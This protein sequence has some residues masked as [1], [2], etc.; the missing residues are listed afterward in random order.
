MRGSLVVGLSDKDMRLLDIFEGDVSTNL[1][2]QGTMSVADGIFCGRNIHENWFS[3]THSVR[4]LLS[5]T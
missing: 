4:R 1:S 5:T 2:T 3:F